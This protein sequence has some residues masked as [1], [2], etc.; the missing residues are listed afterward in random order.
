[1]LLPLAPYTLAGVVWYQGESNI[2]R[3][4]RYERQLRSL[5]SSWRG[6][7][8]QP[9]LPFV[10]VQLPDYMAPSATPQ[11]SSWARLRESQRRAVLATPNAEL[12]V[13]LGLGEAN[14]IHPLRKKEVAERVAQVFD[15]LVFGKP[16]MLAPKPLRAEAQADGTVVVTFDQPV[17]GSHGFELDT[18]GRFHNVEATANGSRV[19]LQGTGRRVRYAWKSNPV[20]ADLRAVTATALPATPFELEVQ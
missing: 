11:E 1:M 10:V 13:T 9:E 2:G 15:R 3:A 19:V 5:M 20:E 17:Q 8:R 12:A 6:T 18:D 16:V 14:D 4:E 7:F